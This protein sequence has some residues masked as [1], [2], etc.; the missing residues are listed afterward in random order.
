MQHEF[1]NIQ[2][3]IRE[4]IRPEEWRAGGNF[5]RVQL[6]G[7]NVFAEFKDASPTRANSNQCRIYFG[8]DPA[9]VGGAQIPFGPSHKIRW[10]LRPETEGAAYA[11]V[12]TESSFVHVWEGAK[13]W[14]QRLTTEQIPTY[15][16]N[17]LAEYAAED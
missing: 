15:L 12:V 10:I 3:R 1:Q 5:P 7:M 16:L 17:R 13:K 4:C 11:W 8:A 6:T 2:M 9:E 14:E